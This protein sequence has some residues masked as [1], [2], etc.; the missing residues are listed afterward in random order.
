[1]R[2]DEVLLLDMVEAA[3]RIETYTRDLDSQ[4]FKADLRT[5][6]AV[7]TRVMIIGEAASKVSRGFKEQHTEVPWAQ[8]IQLRNFYIH[9]YHSI[10]ANRLWQTVTSVIAETERKVGKLLSSMNLPPDTSSGE[11]GDTAP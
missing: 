9:A 5:Q 3:R 2:S 6:D 7:R 1:M 4:S 10:D 8:L 11:Q